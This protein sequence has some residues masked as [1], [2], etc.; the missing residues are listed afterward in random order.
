MQR[1]ATLTAGCLQELLRAGASAYFKDEQGDTA[2][3]CA[4]RAAS[5]QRGELWRLEVLL[6][7]AY[8]LPPAA[9]SEADFAGRLAAAALPCTIP[10]SALVRLLSCLPARPPDHLSHPAALCRCC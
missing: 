3:H 6:R 8:R 5:M 2:L 10:M 9:A 7:T 1:L 4:A